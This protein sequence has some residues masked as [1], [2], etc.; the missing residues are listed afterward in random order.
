VQRNLNSDHV[1]DPTANFSVG[2][3]LS[4]QE[5][6][7]QWVCQSGAHFPQ[8]IAGGREKKKARCKQRRAGKLHAFRGEDSA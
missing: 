7:G 4:L 1:G 5:S 8:L 3:K 6:V 2:L